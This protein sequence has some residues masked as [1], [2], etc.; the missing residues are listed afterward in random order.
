[1]KPREWV[2]CVV[3]VRDAEGNAWAVTIRR[4][5]RSKRDGRL[6]R[7]AFVN[8]DPVAR[9]HVQRRRV[10]AVERVA[11]GALAGLRVLVLGGA[12]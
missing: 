9:Q 5:W 8:G 4:A 3:G 7:V 11:T 12:W 10:V 2:G 1:M 6:T